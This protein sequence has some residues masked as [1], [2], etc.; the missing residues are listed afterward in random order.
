MPFA[1]FSVWFFVGISTV[2]KPVD[3]CLGPANIV[4]FC[5]FFIVTLS[6]SNN[7]V[8]SLSHSCPID[9]RFPDAKFS[10]TLALLADEGT[11]GIASVVVLVDVNVCPFGHST[12]RGCAFTV[13]MFL[14]NIMYVPLAP[15]SGWAVM[16]SFWWATSL[17]HW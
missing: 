16:L 7:A 11:L 2:H 6:F 1:L 5:L 9:N 12:L 14:S 4:S 13:S 15:E 8:H 10:K 17:E 3:C